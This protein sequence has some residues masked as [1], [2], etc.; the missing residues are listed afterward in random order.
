MAVVSV[1]KML[2]S[3]LTIRDDSGTPYLSPKSKISH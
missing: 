2:G 3:F 1:W